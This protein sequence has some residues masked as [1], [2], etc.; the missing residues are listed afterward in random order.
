MSDFDEALA[1]DMNMPRPWGLWTAIK[2]SSLPPSDRLALAAYAT[3]SWG[4]PWSAP[5]S[6]SP[7]SPSE[8]EALIARR[9]AARQAKDFAAADAIRGEIAAKG[10]V[11]EDLPGGKWKVSR[12]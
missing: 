1:D 7:R 5:R 12:K 4:W 6:R 11:L 9:I 10:F 8:V 3:T 2:D